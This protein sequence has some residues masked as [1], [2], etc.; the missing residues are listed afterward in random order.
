MPWPPNQAAQKF[1]TASAKLR[2]LRLF[3]FEKYAGRSKAFVEDDLLCRVAEYD[4]AVKLWGLET[5]HGT[6]TTV[7]SSKLSATVVGSTVL[8]ALFA[9][10]AAAIVS[11][12]VGATV[13]V[14]HV[15]LEFARRRYA[16]QRLTREAPVSFVSYA[17][18]KLQRGAA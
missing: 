17:K 9:Q 3:A 14:G 15:A 16:V 1:G 18:S 8:S 6:L 10:P 7:F 2:R 13:E 12:A 5:V 4:E 11:A